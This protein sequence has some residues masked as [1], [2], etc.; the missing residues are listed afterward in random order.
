MNK[1]PT[2]PRGEPLDAEELEALDEVSP[3]EAVAVDAIPVDVIPP[4]AAAA[5]ANSIFPV[6][7]VDEDFRIR[8]ANRACDRLFSGFYRLAGSLFTDLFGRSLGPT[9]LKEIRS[10]IRSAERG[11]SWKG[12]IRSKAREA[13]TILT[14]TYFVPVYANAESARAPTEFIVLFDDVTEENK[15]LLRSVFLS[16]LEASKLKDNDT[17]KH[18]TRVNRYAR[19]F[20]EELFD[21]PGYDSIDRDFVDD[22][23][24]LAS[25]HDVGKIGTPDDILNKEGPLSDWEWAIMQEHTKNGAYILSTYPNPMAREIALNH[26]ERWDGTGYPFKIEGTMIPLSARI[27]S[28]VDVYDALRMKRSYKN[29]Y[30]HRTAVAKIQ[31][32]RG[33]HFDP[34]LVDVFERIADDF[35]V[36]FRTNED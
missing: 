5:F 26:H 31:D 4:P 16:L 34:A 11:Y 9:T 15:A 23:G 28:L 20:A 3:D 14:K 7:L 30:N 6:L 36:I 1:P 21:H 25:M 2:P 12:L 27:V 13:G 17:G 32:W 22:I 35:E 24:F 19:R 10:A 33:T 18:I 29:A 8:F